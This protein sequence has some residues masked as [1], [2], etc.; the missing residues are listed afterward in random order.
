MPEPKLEKYLRKYYL[1]R[2][3]QHQKDEWPPSFNVKYINLVMIQQSA[4]PWNKSKAKRNIGLIAKGQMESIQGARLCSRDIMTSNGRLCIINGAPGVGKTTLALKLRRDWADR[5]LLFKFHLVLYIPLREPFA[6]LSETVDELLKHFDENCNADDKELI[7]KEHGKGVL[8][9]LDGWDEL[10]LSC[11]GESQFFP[12]LISGS[13]L[14]GCSIIVTSRPGA[15]Q[16]I[17][18]YADQIIEILGFGREQVEE[19]IEAYFA[20]A[21]DGDGASHLI[22][23]LLKYPNIASTCYVAINLAIV[24]HVYQALSYRLPQTLTEIYKWFIIHTILRYLKKKKV[25]EKM[26]EQLP[27][28]ESTEDVFASPKFDQAVQDIFKESVM[29][30]L[31]NLGYL[32]LSGLQHDDLCFCRKDLVS[33]CNLDVNDHQFDG[34]GLLKPV[35]I[36]HLVGSEPYYHFLHL[37]IQE[38]VAAYHLS[39]MQ[40]SE[41]MRWLVHDSKYDNTIKFFC[42]V[43][44]FKSQPLRIFFK[45]AEPLRLFHLECVYEGQWKDHCKVIANRC[46]SSFTLSENNT[47]K[48]QPQQWA[49]LGYVMSNSETQWHFTCQKQIL[50]EKCLTCFTEHLSNKSLHHL[51]L[52]EVDVDHGAVMHLS[53]ICQLQ[54]GLTKLD[55]INC[56]FS[57]EDILTFLKAM[58][59]HKCLEKLCIRDRLVAAAVVSAF[60]KLLPTLSKLK[61]IELDI[62]SFSCQDYL[63]IKQFAFHLNPPPNV[64]VP[65]KLFPEQDQLKGKDQLKSK[66]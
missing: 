61:E 53:E 19:Y 37:S 62:K 55:I 15:S 63:D 44:Q 6:R 49:V 12:R 51:T 46:S 36:S 32:A 27:A 50:D 2:G 66:S 30:T 3:S 13:I 38:F 42:G 58:E 43:N 54:E 1:I 52:E 9:I 24:C 8:F 48:L 64:I 56:V 65:D 28:V 18:C 4:M 33:T 5:K 7:K 57:N 14:P 29:D 22:T 11:R 41:Q 21:C 20:N 17:C 34:L 40:P 47:F 39:Q 31:K 60:W 10:K 45:N 25:A 26:D 59:Y 23:D 35:Q 16:D